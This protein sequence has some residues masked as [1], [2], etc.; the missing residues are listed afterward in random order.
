[1]HYKTNSRSSHVRV[2][3]IN[4]ASNVLVS[5]MCAGMNAVLY[6]EFNNSLQLYCPVFADES[7][8]ATYYKATVAGVR[9]FCRQGSE[10]NQLG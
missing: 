3:L 2:D 8:C 4:I 9:A 5:C 7:L 1:M 6:M 10:I